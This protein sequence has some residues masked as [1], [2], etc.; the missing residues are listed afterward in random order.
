MTTGKS[1]H[2]TGFSGQIDVRIP[3]PGKKA[4]DRVTAWGF[5]RYCDSE[6]QM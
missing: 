2:P 1:A 3:Y 5:N 4:R 6:T